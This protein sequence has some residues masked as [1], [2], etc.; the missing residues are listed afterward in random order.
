MARLCVPPLAVGSSPCWQE[1]WRRMSRSCGRRYIFFACTPGAAI[2]SK[3]SRCIC[4]LRVPLSSWRCL[5]FFA[6]VDKKVRTSKSAQWIEFA[7]CHP[8][9]LWPR[10]IHGDTRQLYYTTT[11]LHEF[12]RSTINQQMFSSTGLKWINRATWLP[13]TLT[14]RHVRTWQL[15]DICHVRTYLVN[16]FP[17][18]LIAH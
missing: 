14:L 3:I 10:C 7:V 9:N 2:F 12:N 11:L 8:A 1:T 17:S 16:V 5:G 6:I 18:P 13:Q 4:L 15:Q